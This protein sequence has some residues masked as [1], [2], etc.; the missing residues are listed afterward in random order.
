MPSTPQDKPPSSSSSQVRR[1]G[2]VSDGLTDSERKVLVAA[3]VG[4]M[5]PSLGPLVQV[6]AGCR[7]W[8]RWQAQG[9]S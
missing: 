5:V 7:L 4:D 3:M 2:G 1:G 9:G 6:G 8:R